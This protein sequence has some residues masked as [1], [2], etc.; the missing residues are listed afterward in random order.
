M[1]RQR[2]LTPWYR[3]VV[4]SRSR[5]D[6]AK[7]PP[8]AGLPGLGTS[9][10]MSMREQLDDVQ[11]QLSPNFRSVSRPV[12]TWRG[13]D[14]RLVASRSE[15][16]LAVCVYCTMS[17]PLRRCPGRR[18]LFS[19]A[20]CGAR[21]RTPTSTGMHVFSRP[22]FG[23]G[24]VTSVRGGWAGSGNRWGAVPEPC[25]TRD[26]LGAHLGKEPEPIVHAVVGVRQ[27]SLCPPPS[28]NTGGP[29]HGTSAKP[30]KQWRQRKLA[31]E[32]DS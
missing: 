11:H 20:V 17:V 9:L 1:T 4:V 19:G 13:E 14:C 25:E 29:T 18:D 8:A 23:R 22:S 6:P 16:S 28:V 24:T 15:F 3:A 10:E 12:V 31:R 27:D 7:P 2:E 32:R 26:K 21:H 30:W 5:G